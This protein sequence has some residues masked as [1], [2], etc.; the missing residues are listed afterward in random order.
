MRKSVFVIE[1]AFHQDVCHLFSTRGW[2]ISDT[3]LITDLLCF[4]GGA[5]VDPSWYNER[6]THSASSK[7]LDEW[8][9]QFWDKCPSTPKVGICRGGQLL[10][11]WNG[12]LMWQ[13][14]VGHS[15]VHK[16][17]DK[18]TGTTIEVTSLHHQLM[19]PSNDGTVLAFCKDSSFVEGGGVRINRD[20]NPN[21]EDVEAV[22]YEKT[23]SLCFQPH[24]ELRSAPKACSDYFFD[25]IDKHLFPKTEVE[26]RP[27][28]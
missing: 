17:T 1:G 14:M 4:T 22:F 3:P 12:G 5:D 28:E 23:K 27:V 24:P 26:V 15:G 18:E 25:L 2:T 10:N 9:R 21:Y 6:N 7:E 8:E 13:N 16:I 19:R 20:K 11:V